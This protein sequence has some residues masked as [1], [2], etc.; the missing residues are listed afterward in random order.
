MIPVRCHNP[1]AAYHHISK[2]VRAATVRTKIMRNSQNARS[3]DGVNGTRNLGSNFTMKSYSYS[4]GD[5]WQPGILNTKVSSSW[6]AAA[7]IWSASTRRNCANASRHGTQTCIDGFSIANRL[8]RKRTCSWKANRTRQIHWHR[9]ARKIQ[10]AR[11]ET[12]EQE[13]FWRTDVK[14]PET[15]YHGHRCMDT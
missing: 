12:G 13:L 2:A 11:C 15:L 7:T 8:C 1:F 5:A 3:S 6:N 10:V 9:A 4:C 14:S